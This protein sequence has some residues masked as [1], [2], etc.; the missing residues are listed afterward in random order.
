MSDEE[1]GTESSSLPTVLPS[2]SLSRCGLDTCLGLHQEIEEKL[3]TVE[4]G[5]G[6]VKLRINLDRDFASAYVLG[7]QRTKTGWELTE[8]A[9]VEY[10]FVSKTIRARVEVEVS[11]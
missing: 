10:S 9:G 8:L 6:N 4:P 11:W 1:V 7:A 2:D 3:G 5:H